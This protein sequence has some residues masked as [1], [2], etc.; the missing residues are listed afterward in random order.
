MKLFLL[1]IIVALLSFV[2]AQSPFINL[3]NMDPQTL[4]NLLKK[5]WKSLLP[6]DLKKVVNSF[7]A[8]KH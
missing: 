3:M 6:E 7:T 8:K 2:S 5:D 1:T 4:P